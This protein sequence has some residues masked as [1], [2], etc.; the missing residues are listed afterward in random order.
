MLLTAHAGCLLHPCTARRFAVQ[1]AEMPPTAGTTV[2]CEHV[3][4]VHMNPEVVS[5]YI[6]C[7]NPSN[8]VR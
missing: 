7:P 8:V 1:Y 2:S 4:N 5:A 6:M 3:L